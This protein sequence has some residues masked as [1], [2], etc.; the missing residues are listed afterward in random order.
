MSQNNKKGKIKMP[1]LPFLI[2]IMEG[3]VGFAAYSPIDYQ[4]FMW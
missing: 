1:P 4:N 2:R 3:N